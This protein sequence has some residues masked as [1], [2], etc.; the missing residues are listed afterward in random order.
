MDSNQK[1]GFKSS[2]ELLNGRIAML[3]F[4][5]LFLIEAITKKGILSFF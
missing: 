4:V 2:S 3:G 1:F 5:L